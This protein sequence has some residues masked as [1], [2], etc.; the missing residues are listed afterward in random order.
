MKIVLD[1]SCDEV[2]ANQKYTPGHFID[3]AFQ[4][5]ELQIVKDLINGREPAIILFGD[6]V[7]RIF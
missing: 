7:H 6:L 4:S 2:I 3:A 1:L 5:L